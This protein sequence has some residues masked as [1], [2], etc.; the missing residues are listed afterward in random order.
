MIL[1]PLSIATIGYV[2]PFTATSW[3]PLPLPI[4]SHGYIVI[5]VPTGLPG[6]ADPRSRFHEPFDRDYYRTKY[7][8]EYQR[9]QPLQP[10]VEGSKP[11]PISVL[12]EAMREDTAA[13][14]A[15]RD[16][17]RL[18]ARNRDIDRDI[19]ELQAYIREVSTGLESGLAAQVAAAELK[20]ADQ[21]AFLER[22]REAL[23]DAREA[24][25]VALETKRRRQNQLAA[26]EAVIR[27]YF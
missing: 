21:A 27:Y 12:P 9:R 22:L 23:I 15:T 16:L 18:E 25:L 4:S 19:L 10:P 20:A 7:R 1:D 13:A 8:R 5:Q 6:M 26:I 17:A 14:Q 11:E 3:A 2:A 24:L